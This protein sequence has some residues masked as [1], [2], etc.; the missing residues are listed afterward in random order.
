MTQSSNDDPSPVLERASTSTNRVGRYRLI[1]H[2]GSG[3]MADVYLAVSSGNGTRFQK[4]LVV[5]VLKPELIAEPD[6]IEMFLDEARLAA[7][8]S[9]PHVVQTLEVGEDA[10]RYFLAMEY[11]EG[12]PLNRLIK[13]TDGL[14]AFDLN[15]RLT[16]L[17]RALAGLDYAHELV[18]YDG[19]PLHVVHRDVSPGNILVGYDGQIK[20][21]DFGIAKARDSTTETRI[22]VFKG[23]TAYMAPEQAKGGELDRRADIYSAGVILWE[24]IVGR[25]MWQGL[26]Q[27]E[28]LSRMIAGSVPIPSKVGA[29]VSPVLERICLKALALRKEDRYP[30]AAALS[31][32]IESFLRLNFP[33][34]SDRELGRVIAEAFSTDRARIRELIET[35]LSPGVQ[36]S[37]PPSWAASEAPRTATG[38]TAHLAPTSVVLGQALR[39][40]AGQLS[41]PPAPPSISQPPV[42]LSQPPPSQLKRRAGLG[43]GALVIAGAIFAVGFREKQPAAGSAEAAPAA[44]AAL[45]EHGV[46]AT[47]AQGITPTEITLGMSAVFS[48]PTRQ[49]G[50]NMKL[51]LETAFWAANQQGGVHGRKLTLIALDDGYEASRVVGTMR[52]LIEQRRVF[53]VVG[54]VGTPTSALAA[55]YASQQKTVFF[56]A[57]TGAPVLRQD[58]PDRYVFNYRASYREETA[59]TIAYLTQVQKLPI[60]QIVVFAQDDSFGDAGYDGVAKAVRLLGRTNRDVLRV[61]YKRNSSDVDAALAQVVRYNDQSEAVHVANSTDV[62]RVQ[63]HPV[64]AVVMVATYRAASKFIQKLREVPRLG[65]PLFFNVSFVGTEALADDLKSTNPSLCSNVFVTQVVPPFASG[66]TGVRRYREVLAKYQPQ[67]Q[68]GFVSLEGFI[69]GSTFVEALQQAGASLNTERLVDT[70]EQF[71]AVDLGFGAQLS[72]SLSEHQGSHKVWGTRL[73]ENCAVLPA[74]LE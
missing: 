23:K 22:G 41:L 2:L 64:K 44:A 9:H 67:A 3:G 55:P 6:F 74:D 61:G 56:G 40:A 38:T 20:L 34:K 15:F 17:V 42:V 5:K 28:I 31:E 66:S 51:G 18:D 11:I 49:L 58:P 35:E 50:E 63:K 25:R 43:V 14:N 16:V 70:L 37:L 32:D 69:V 60:E 33:A 30:S 24:L 71:K 1:A 36:S 4:L 45:V 72:F 52:E 39:Q 73:D 47:P 8:L 59:A 27:A 54:N 62:I 29:N 46:H 68:P 57:F 53:A 12:Q 26:T 7:R 65:K 13:G 48:G 10:G 19:S 21:T